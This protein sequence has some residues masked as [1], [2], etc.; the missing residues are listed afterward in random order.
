MTSDND[1]GFLS[2][3]DV[4]RQQQGRAN[5]EDQARLRL[6]EHKKEL[7]QQAD[8]VVERIL[9]AFARKGEL[10][11]R[12]NKDAGDFAWYLA[13]ATATWSQAPLWV[14]LVL[15]GSEPTLEFHVRPDTRVIKENIEI[16]GQVLHNETSWNVYKL[17]SSG[18]QLTRVQEWTQ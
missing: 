4:R 18:T 1:Y 3:D 8:L 6:N 11:F 13:S 10:T 5:Q 9:N 17:E 16:L 15:D 2:K 14:H 12:A 7:Y